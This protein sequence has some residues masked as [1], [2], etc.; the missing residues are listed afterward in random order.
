[1]FLSRRTR[2]G[3]ST[4]VQ[5]DTTEKI[6]DK[7]GSTTTNI[8]TDNQFIFSDDS[9]LLQKSK[10]SPL[11]PPSVHAQQK[12]R[13]FSNV[14]CTH[15][16]MRETYRSCL[17]YNICYRNGEYYYFQNDKDYSRRSTYYYDTNGFGASFFKDQ[18]TLVGLEGRTNFEKPERTWLKIHALNESISSYANREKLKVGW[19]TKKSVLLKRHRCTNAAHCLTETIYPA[20][21]LMREFFEVNPF[22]VEGLFEF[23]DTYLVFAEEEDEECDCQKDM[24]TCGTDDSDVASKKRA[25]QTFVRRYGNIVSKYP[26]QLIRTISKGNDMTCFSNIVMG[27]TSYGLFGDLGWRNV[28]GFMKQF[29]DVIYQ[30]HNVKVESS[31]KRLQKKKLTL[32][33]YNKK[34][35]FRRIERVEELHQRAQTEFGHYTYISQDLTIEFDVKINLVSFESLSFEEQIHL[36]YETD[37][38]LSPFGSASFNSVLMSSGAVLLTFPNG[39][40]PS[41]SENRIFEHDLFHGHMWYQNLIYPSLADE[42]FFPP[43]AQAGSYL[44]KWDK[45]RVFITTALN[46]RIN[47]LVSTSYD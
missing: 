46:M 39:Y 37:I 16:F 3:N 38:F 21:A 36:M 5:P 31:E 26:N 30:L 23:R 11:S 28:G 13:D 40:E 41:P 6:T 2:G 32:T 45:M 29:R 15:N 7:V 42:I 47:Y 18:S 24:I 9:Y 4:T 27:S 22:T 25:C 10:T 35:G 14:F 17:V 19:V 34:R 33:I 43:H 20:F 44:W 1:M 12:F 8:P